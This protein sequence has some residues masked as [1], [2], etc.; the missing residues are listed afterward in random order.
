MAWVEK[1]KSKDG[2]VR[3]RIR[4]RIAGEKVTVVENAGQ[5]KPVADKA[6]EAYVKRRAAGEDPQVQA[7]LISIEEAMEAFIHH[8]PKRARTVEG[9]RQAAKGFIAHSKISVVNKVTKE[10]IDAW[11]YAMESGEVQFAKNGK[12]LCRYSVWTAWTYARNMRA[13]L[14]F[15]SKRGWIARHIPESIVLREPKATPRFLTAPEVACFVRACRAPS[16]RSN[17]NLRR[18]ILFGLYTGMRLGEVLAAHWEHLTAQEIIS[19]TTRGSLQTRV[20][21]VLHIPVAK[22]DKE[23]SVAIHPRLAGI[24][25]AHRFLEKRGPIFPTWS[26]DKLG[27]ARR[28]AVRRA[29]LGRIRFHDLRHSFVRNYLKSGAG[30]IA[31]L[32]LQT[33]HATLASLQPYAHFATEDIAATISKMKVQ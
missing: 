32:R 7:L 22:G 25:G 18:I 28:R 10:A 19:R 20:V 5:W 30:T 12:R 16:R 17:N 23:R 11:R 33:G 1:R 15:C 8:E 14:Y 27:H 26:V 29:G 6:L 9:H 4:D 13:F 21:Y 24:I 2:R 3:Y 31:Q